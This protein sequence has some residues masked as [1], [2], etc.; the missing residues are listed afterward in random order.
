VFGGR[1]C[2]AS[3]GACRNDGGRVRRSARRRPLR[4]TLP[5]L[6]NALAHGARAD[7]SVVFAIVATS[8]CDPCEDAARRRL[9]RSERPFATALPGGHA[10]FLSVQITRIIFTGTLPQLT[11]L[12]LIATLDLR[13]VSR[14]TPHRTAPA[15]RVPLACASH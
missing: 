12:D 5:T 4:L 3:G 11:L 10:H 8:A 14:H 7:P 13:Y 6:A 15:S 2:V 1:K 9:M